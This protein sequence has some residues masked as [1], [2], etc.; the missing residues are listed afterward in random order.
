MQQTTTTLP[1]KVNYKHCFF[2][3]VYLLVIVKSQAG[4]RC[5]LS[6]NKQQ[7]VSLNVT[8]NTLKMA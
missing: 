1:D 6:F 2:V 5:I 7:F 8:D 4:F 3:T